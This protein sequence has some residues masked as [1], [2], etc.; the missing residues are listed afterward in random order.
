MKLYAGIDLHGKNLVLSVVDERNRQ[1]VKVRLPLFLERILTALEPYREWLAGIAVES[2]YNWYWLV[3]GLMDAGY[4]VKLVN[5]AKVPQYEGLKHRG[6]DDDAR[7]LAWL[8]HL[9]LL[10]VGWICPRETRSVRDLLRK[11]GQLVR[12]RT[13][14]VLSIQSQYARCGGRRIS[15][16]T[17]KRL[18]PIKIYEDFPDEL[19]A[20]AAMANSAVCQRLEDQIRMIERIVSP[21][22]A[23]DG[24]YQILTTIPGVGKILGATI[25]LETGDVGRFR[26]VG[27]FASYC[28]CV[29]SVRV[30]A[31]KKKG[32]GNR[33]NGNKHLSWA[34]QEAACHCRQYHA[35]ARRWYDRKASRAL[36]FVAWKA[37]A[38]KLSRAAYFMMR[39]QV[40]FSSAMLFG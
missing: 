10:P 6:D 9:G 40:E 32:E 36:P 23:G 39:D 19:Q 26:T 24:A 21:R 31:G 37:L 30:S 16:E 8:Q 3:D 20:M 35:P 14:N 28:R 34:F 4:E 33:K 11:R 15:G 7:W 5:T 38:H 13:A 18:H 25:A 17:A 22:L 1:A 2:T 12:Q 29:P 27:D